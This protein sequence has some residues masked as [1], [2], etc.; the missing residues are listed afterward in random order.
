MGVPVSERSSIEWTD[1]TLNPVTGCTKVSPGCAHCYAEAVTLRFKRG[2]AFLPG[3]SEVVLHSDRLRLPLSWRRG[4]RIFVNSMSDLFHEEVPDEFILEVFQMMQAA[5]WHVFQLLTKRPERL[6]AMSSDLPWPSNLWMGVSVENQYWADRRLPLLVEVPAAVRFVSLEPLLG[7]V[8]MG[9][10]L[11]RLHWVVVGGESGP[12]CRKMQACWV[13]SVRDAC[14]SADVAF[15]FKQ[16]GGFVPAAG[17]REL[18]GREWSEFP[19][20]YPGSES[21]L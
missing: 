12:R 14:V 7:P 13:R 5:D 2:P 11:S 9:S 10:S 4:R 6:L 17:G 15:F 20:P 16:W 21:S 3:V 19:A 8:Q 18:D 1:S